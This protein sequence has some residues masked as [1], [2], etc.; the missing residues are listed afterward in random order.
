MCA[1]RLVKEHH[2]PM[3]EI[4]VFVKRQEQHVLIA[5]YFSGSRQPRV[6]ETLSIELFKEKPED[7]NAVRVLGICEQENAGALQTEPYMVF[8]ILAEA[9]M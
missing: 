1:E 9:V 6:G 5:E 3:H 2:V 7:P 8:S 4:R